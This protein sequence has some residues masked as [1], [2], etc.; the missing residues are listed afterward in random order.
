MDS[1]LDR[2]EQELQV[3]L[4]AHPA[5]PYLIAVSGGLDSMLLLTLMHKSGLP[6]EA[7]HVN[8]KLRSTASDLD[9]QLVQDF[10]SSKQIK[11]HLYE[12]SSKEQR[13]LKTSN[14]Q[15]KARQIRYDFFA[16]IAQQYPQHL[17][18]TAQHA[19]DQQETFWLQCFRGAG[20]KGMAGMS[21]VENQIFRPFLNLTKTQLLEAA[22]ALKL[23]WR[24]DQSNLSVQYRRNLWRNQL[25]PALESEIPELLAA[26]QLIQDCFQAEIKAQTKALKEIQK[27][28]DIKSSIT[29]KEISLLTVFQ[30]IELFKNCSVPM[31]IIRRIPTLFKAKNG[32]RLTWTRS[33]ATQALVRFKDQIWLVHELKKVEEISER[34]NEQNENGNKIE[35]TEQ[36]E[37]KLE[38][39]PQLPLQYDLK[40]AYIDA[41]K[42]IG[43]IVLRNLNQQ[44]YI[45][46]IGLN[47]KK[48]AFD[49][50][51]EHGIPSALRSQY[52][53][54][55]DNEKLLFIPNFKIDKRAVANQHTTQILKITVAKKR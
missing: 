34:I 2:V 49:I 13:D 31:H 37:L 16:Q 8:Y 53:G 15:A 22:Q 12:V 40:T 28:F 6:I 4:A 18:C 36:L 38:I 42:T 41:E 25:L 29:L 1:S 24:E 44:D 10:C 35:K 5:N 17:I 45:Y 55:F 39:C 51:K 48:L 54:V 43:Q 33:N 50:L 26:T 32:A 30:F 7:L 19:N 27:E 46:P 14:L 23:T 9:A 21:I 3:Q 52:L 11:F 20:M 47:G